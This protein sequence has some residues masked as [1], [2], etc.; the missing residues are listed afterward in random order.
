MGVYT[1]PCFWAKF[2]LGHQFFHIPR[3]HIKLL[4]G[5]KHR[6]RSTLRLVEKSTLQIAVTLP[7]YHRHPTTSLGGR[8][9]VALLGGSPCRYRYNT[10]QCGQRCQFNKASSIHISTSILV[11]TRKFNFF[12][13][14]SIENRPVFKEK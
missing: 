11:S 1:P 7:P 12:I 8:R 13:Q 4:P 6:T 9:G 3:R 5:G 14:Y 10:C 2:T